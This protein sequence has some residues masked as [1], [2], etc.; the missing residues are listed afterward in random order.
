MSRAVPKLVLTSAKA[1]S[2][3]YSFVTEGDPGDFRSWALCTVNDQT[4]ELI[5]TSDWGNWLHRWH[6]SPEALGAPTL[7]A[8]IGDRTEVD[9]LARKLQGGSRGGERFSAERTAG[10]LRR[11]LCERRLRD[12]REQLEH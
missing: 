6:A 3:T 2:I 8:F 1:A 7:T 9:Y 10:A 12:G 4:G 5:I 11:M